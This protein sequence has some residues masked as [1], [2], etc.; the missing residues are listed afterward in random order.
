MH[1]ILSALCLALALASAGCIRSTTAIDLHPDGSGTIVQ[2]TAVSAQALAMLKGMAAGNQTGDAPTELFSEEQARKTA[3]AMGVTFVSGEPIKTADLDGYRAKFSFDD[4]SKV[5]VSMEQGASGIAGGDSKQPPFSFSFDR[6]P[7]SSLLTIQMPEQMPGGKA[8]P[9]LPG[10]GAGASDAD[11]AQAAQAMAMMKMMMR[12]LF[13]DVALNVD[14]RI[15]KSNA[16]HVEGSRVTLLQI[17]FDK[18]LADDTAFQRLQSATD[19]KS[20]ENIPGLKI[21]SDPK[22][23]IEFA[24]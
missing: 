15:L 17:D 5:K 16:T 21:V 6:G 9:G 11:K 20:L 23:T 7:S 24:R 14:G 13:V 8:L 12:G 2:E 1:R 18:L 22:L 19:V 3:A 10:A 4:I